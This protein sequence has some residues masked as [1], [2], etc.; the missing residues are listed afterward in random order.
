[1]SVAAIQ[2]QE[3]FPTSISTYE[4]I[5]IDKIGS[6]AIHGKGSGM[7]SELRAFAKGEKD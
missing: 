6:Q 2:S 3:A 7:S 1:M 5:H 4:A